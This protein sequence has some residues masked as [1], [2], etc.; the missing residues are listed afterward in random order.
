M[1]LMSKNRQVRCW[2]RN[3]QQLGQ[4]TQGQETAGTETTENE[5][6]DAGNSPSTDESKESGE[7]AEKPEGVEVASSGFVPNQTPVVSY[8]QDKLNDFDYLIQ[9]FYVVD[10]TTTINS[11]QLNAADLLSRSMKRHMGQ[12]PRRYSSIILIHRSGLPILWQEIL[13]LQSWVL[14]HI[15]INC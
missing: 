8:A 14:V 9:N 6:A 12:I 15:C 1:K 2:H 11:T 3:N 4:K 10:R 7:A 5:I 13:L